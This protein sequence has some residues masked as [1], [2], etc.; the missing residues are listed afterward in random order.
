LPPPPLRENLIEDHCDPFRVG[1]PIIAA[2]RILD[3]VAADRLIADGKAD[4]VGMTRAL[5]TDP[6]FAR[7]AAAGRLSEIVRCIGCNTCSTGTTHGAAGIR[8]LQNPVAGRELSFPRI[9]RS[10]RSRR[11]VVVGAGPAGLA[12]AATV[13]EG[14]HEV[15]VLERLDRIGGQIAL[16]STAPTQEETARSLIANYRG[17]LERARVEL[18]LNAEADPDAIA[19]LEPDGTIVATGAEPYVPKALA[20]GAMWQAWDVLRGGCPDQDQVVVADW[21]GDASGLACAEVLA[22]KGKNVTIALGAVA[23]GE[24]MGWST[25]DMYLERLYRAGVKIEHHVELVPGANGEA[26]FRNIFAVELKVDLVAGALVLALGRVP[27]DA[28]APALESRGRLI[29]AAGDCLS[30]RSAEEA[31]L[32]GT[33]AAQRLVATLDRAAVPQSGGP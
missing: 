3:P 7:K 18:R 4:A 9:S 11:I 32:E 12:A 10:A 6:D 26:T 8:C 14:G 13:A 21:G 15:I 17:A 24:T 2:S 30:P 1:L 33:L 29:E 31:I 22:A 25:R 5:I 23:V 16:A 20:A 27:L 19:T 28:L